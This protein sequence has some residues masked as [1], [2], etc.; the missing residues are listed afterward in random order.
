[1][2]LNHNSCFDTL[3]FADDQVIIAKS[4]DDRQR[5]IFNLQKIMS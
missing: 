2:L 3:L 1:M 4:E 5:A